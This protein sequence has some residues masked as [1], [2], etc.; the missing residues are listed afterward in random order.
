MR[1]CRYGTD[2]NGR[3]DGREAGARGVDVD[4]RQE[5]ALALVG[6]AGPDVKKA[7]LRGLSTRA[8]IGDAATAAAKCESDNEQTTAE[9]GW[10]LPSK[11]HGL[12]A[13]DDR[14]EPVFATEAYS[15]GE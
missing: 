5:V 10:R 9:H 13:L 4:H 6:V 12:W 3:D 1:R 15:E 11:S 14:V 7:A 8:D 2:G